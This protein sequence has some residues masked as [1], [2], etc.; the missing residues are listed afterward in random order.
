MRPHLR[1]LIWSHTYRRSCLLQILQRH[2]HHSE[3]Y[4]C[5]E[6]AC[7]LNTKQLT[8]SHKGQ[9]ILAVYEDIFY[10][11]LKAFSEAGL[12]CFC[13]TV[14]LVHQRQIGHT[15]NKVIVN[16][17]LAHAIHCHRDKDVR[18]EP[19]WRVL[20]SLYIYVVGLLLQRW[21]NHNYSYNPERR[22][23]EYHTREYSRSCKNKWTKRRKS[24]SPYTDHFSLLL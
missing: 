16:Q 10:G 24:L 15:R 2:T 19:A 1:K 13:F 5:I 14:E 21:I 8:A 9:F 6:N 18:R 7:W 22:H 23:L 3:Q 4:Q 20:E 11:I 12:A 17:P